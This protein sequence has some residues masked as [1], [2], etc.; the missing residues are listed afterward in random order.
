M[1]EPAIREVRARLRAAAA[2]CV[3]TMGTF[4]GVHHGH[5]ALLATTRSLADAHGLAAVAVTLAQRPEQVF[6]PDAALPDICSL[7]ERVGRLRAA[8]VDGVV[9]L[10]FDR[11]VAE[12]DYRDFARMLIDDLGMRVL[13]VGEDFGFGRRRLGTPA[14]L[15]ELGI[16]VVGH[17]LVP[18]AA[19]TDKASSSSI[20]DALAAGVPRAVAMA[21]A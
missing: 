20:R 2:P 21:S 6:R 14:R 7:D 19:G 4:D 16:D 10:P 9:V 18:N 13:V 17:P 12:I 3:V 11:A 8:G 1:D 15:R 5:R